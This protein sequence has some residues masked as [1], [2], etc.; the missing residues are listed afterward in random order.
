MRVANNARG[1]E[2]NRLKERSTEVQRIADSLKAKHDDMRQWYNSIN[3]TLTEG[4]KNIKDNVELCAKRV[5]I[6]WSKR[7]KHMEILRK[8]YQDKEDPCNPDT[9]ASSQQQGASESTQIIVYKPQQTATRQRTSGGAQEEL[10]QLERSHYVESS[11]TGKDLVVKST[12]LALNRV[13]PVTGEELEEGELIADFTDEQIVALN[14]MKAI[15]DVAINQIPSEPETTDLENLEE[16]VFEDWLKENVDD[17]GEHLKNRDAT[18]NP[19]DALIDW[20]RQLLSKVTKHT[21]AEVQVHYLKYEK[22]NLHGRIL[23]WMFVE[24][25]RCMAIK[26]EHDIQYF[27]SLLSIPS[28]PFYDVTALRKME[29]INRSNFEGATFFARKLKINRRIG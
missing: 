9:S 16:I 7:C 15:E 29:L 17:I 21:L 26:R 20:R 13:H 28:L 3:T 12:D 24:N 27:R 4:F 22:E 8:H 1:I 25:I 5:N 10:P 6:M 23:C 18:D 2:M 11:S 14:E 19:P